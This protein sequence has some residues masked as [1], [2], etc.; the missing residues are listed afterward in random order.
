MPRAKGFPAKSALKPGACHALACKWRAN[1]FRHERVANPASQALRVKSAIRARH[2]RRGQ[3]RCRILQPMENA[4]EA[5]HFGLSARQPV[6]AKASGM[7]AAPRMTRHASRAASC[8]A[9]FRL[10]LSR[11]QHPALR[12][13]G[14]AP[15]R[16]DRSQAPASRAQEHSR[17]AATR[18]SANR[19]CHA[20][21]RTHAGNTP[22][23]ARSG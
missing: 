19:P 12:Y 22:A 17:R 2:A 14:P 11:P 5:A 16:Q 8:A 7:Q 3:N 9:L 18:A 10:C 1:E 6:Q 13:A 21:G 4:S 20:S 23:S 15:V